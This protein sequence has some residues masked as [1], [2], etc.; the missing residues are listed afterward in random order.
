M[1]PLLIGIF[2]VILFIVFLVLSASTW[3]GWHI[4]AI[5]LTFL[6][7]MGFVVVR[8]CRSERT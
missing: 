2:L 7:A 6:A 3:R 5:C 4:A 1:I 8:P